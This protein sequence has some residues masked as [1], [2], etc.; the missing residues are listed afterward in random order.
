ML[1]QLFFPTLCNAYIVTSNH[2]NFFRKKRF[3]FV[4]VDD[5]RLRLVNLLLRIRSLNLQ[6]VISVGVELEVE[7]VKNFF[8]DNQRLIQL[9][10]LLVEV[11]RIIEINRNKQIKGILMDT[12]NW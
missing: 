6:L 4:F 11:T 9:I 1:F 2:L 3:N 7:N 12:F 10:K 8:S 5:G